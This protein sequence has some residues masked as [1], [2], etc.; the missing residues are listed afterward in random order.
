MSITQTSFGLQSKS[1]TTKKSLFNTN[2]I[3][4]GNNFFT[5]DLFPDVWD[6]AVW[7]IYICPVAS[8]I[9]TVKRTQTATATV[10]FELLNSGVALTANSAYVFTIFVSKGESINFRYS[11]NSVISK[12]TVQ[13]MLS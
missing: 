2:S 1:Y 13:E 9:L 4:A 7:N 11:V 12:M 3:L 5:P 6:T 8:G 10:V